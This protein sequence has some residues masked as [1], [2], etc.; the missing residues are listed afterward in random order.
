MNVA[1]AAH[2]KLVPLPEAILGE[3]F[4]PKATVI[5]TGDVLAWHGLRGTLLRIDAER[6]LAT[7]S[8]RGPT[9]VWIVTA[10]LGMLAMAP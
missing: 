1:K 7:V 10:P 9:D 3:N 8:L 4:D 2:E 6:D 5:F